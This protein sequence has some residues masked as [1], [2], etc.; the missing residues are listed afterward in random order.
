MT[1][2]NLNTFARHGVFDDQRLT[3]RIAE[4]LRDK[5]AIKRARVFP[6]QLMVA[7]SQAS[8]AVPGVVREALQDAMEIATAA[9]PQVATG[10][11]V[12]PDVSGSMHSPV[13]GRRAGA[14]SVVRCIDVAA[15]VAATVMRTNPHAEVVPFS[16]AVVDVRLNPRDSIMTNAK[17]MSSLPAG[18]TNCSAP[19]AELNRRRATGELVIYVSDNESWVDRHGRPATATLEQW[20]VFKARNP[21]AKLVCIDLQPYG[22]TQA[23]ERADVLNVGGFSDAVFEVIAAFAAGTLG[24]DHW[25]RGGRGDEDLRR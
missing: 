21:A 25:G 12:L 8:A 17:V 14:S 10:V 11:Y 4:R 18:G 3:R 20:A 7:H 15:L 16:D 2:M 13:T 22:T 5:D 19:L 24:T 1:R 9:V 6:Y 23:A